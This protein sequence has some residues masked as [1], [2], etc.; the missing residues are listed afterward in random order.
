VS[1]GASAEALKARARWLK[2]T[3][4]GALVM[5]LLIML[6]LYPP[7]LPTPLLP[8]CLKWRFEDSTAPPKYPLPYVQIKRVS[9]DICLPVLSSLCPSDC[10]YS[11]LI[12]YWTRSLGDMYLTAKYLKCAVCARN[13]YLLFLFPASPLR[14]S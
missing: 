7:F 14:I 11:S 2:A 6:I 12:M 3:D 5:S 10:L 1:C 4:F 13:D 8:Y 9:A